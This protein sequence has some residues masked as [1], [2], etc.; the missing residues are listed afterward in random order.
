MCLYATSF[1]PTCP[2]HACPRKQ[3]HKRIKVRVP[4]ITSSTKKYEEKLEKTIKLKNLKLYLK[5]KSIIE[6]NEKLRKKAV[7]LHQENLALLS[8]F[9]KKFSRLPHF[10]A[11]LHHSDTPLSAGSTGHQIEEFR[12]GIV[13]EMPCA[14]TECSTKQRCL[15]KQQNH[16]RKTEI[17]K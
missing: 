16:I 4:S 10:S 1:F 2:M 13:K 14:S 15:R 8:E 3:V 11:T 9:Q 5:N 6:E 17:E 7:R 12:L